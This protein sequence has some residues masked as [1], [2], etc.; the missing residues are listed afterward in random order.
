MAKKIFK[1]EQIDYIQ[2]HSDQ[3]QEACIDYHD[4]DLDLSDDII[5]KTKSA[6]DQIDEIF[7]RFFDQY[8]ILEDE[9]LSEEERDEKK[10]D[11]FFNNGGSLKDLMG[12]DL[13]GDNANYQMGQKSDPHN[14]LREESDNTL[15]RTSP[16]L[17]GEARDLVLPPP[18][19]ASL[20]VPIENAICRFKER[21]TLPL[22]FSLLQKVLTQLREDLVDSKKSSEERQEI[23]CELFKFYTEEYE[24]PIIPDWLILG[25]PDSDEGLLCE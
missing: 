7:Y 15:N 9:G 19:L 5:K 23:Y 21:N 17:K 16:L 3:I 20:E 12:V 10:E 1:E 25:M 8:E 2:F 13:S 14:G 6:C 18:L 11:E 24:E 4:E 22:D